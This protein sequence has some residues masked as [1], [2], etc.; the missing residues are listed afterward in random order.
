MATPVGPT[1]RIGSVGLPA[2][3]FLGHRAPSAPEQSFPSRVLT[4]ETRAAATV[5]VASLAH[6]RCPPNIPASLVGCCSV[7]LRRSQ[8]DHQ[9][10]PSVLTRALL[11]LHAPPPSFASRDPVLGPS[12]V[13]F[14]LWEGVSE[15]FLSFWRRGAGCSGHFYHCF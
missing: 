6:P 13:L 10:L 5:G 9:R 4:V 1:L 3:P 15:L 7:T 2:A 12:V 8:L 11:P 14:K